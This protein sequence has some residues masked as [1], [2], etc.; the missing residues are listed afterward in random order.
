MKKIGYY[1]IP[2]LKVLLF[3][4]FIIICA[5]P[6]SLLDQYGIIEKGSISPLALDIVAEAVIV[7]IILSALLMLFKVY[8]TYHF[9]T[10]FIVRQNVVSG[11]IKGTLIGFIVLV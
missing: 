4:I 9:S 8:R 6:F 5:I 11:F 1:T 10:I 7:V 2:L 3:L